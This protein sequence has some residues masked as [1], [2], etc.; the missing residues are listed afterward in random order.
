MSRNKDIKWLHQLTELLYSECRKKMKEH[1]WDVGAALEDMLESDLL[2]LRG[3]GNA[4]VDSLLDFAEALRETIATLDPLKEIAVAVEEGLKVPEPKF[5]ML[6]L[7]F[8]DEVKKNAL[9]KS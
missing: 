6:E 1:H 3:T 4:V 5:E 7:S 8:H 9:D 2:N